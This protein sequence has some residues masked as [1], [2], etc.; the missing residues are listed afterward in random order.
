MRE[1]DE[2]IGGDKERK[3][4]GKKGQLCCQ[5]SEIE[6]RKKVLIVDD[7]EINVEI[8]K[9]LLEEEYALAIASNGQQCLEIIGQFK[10]DL[11]LLDIVMP[12]M[13]GYE[14]CRRIKSDPQ[15]EATH[16][17]LVS[18]KTSIESRLK[19]YDAGTDDY[20]M[21]PFDSDE[22]LAKIQVQIR[23]REAITNLASLHAQLSEELRLAGIV[24]RDFLP[25]KL[26][27]CERLRWATF[28]LPAGSVSGDIY[29]VKHI[30]E[31]HVSFYVA[32]AV[33]HGMPAALLSIFIKQAIAMY[34]DTQNSSCVL[35]PAEL[36]KNVNLRISAQKLSGFLFITC[37]YC[38]ININT[39]QLTYCRAGHPYPIL[40]RQK[41][42]PQHLEI[43]GS[44]LGIVEE[45]EYSQ[46]TIQLQSGDKLLLYSD[47]A[48][49]FIS[50]SND[51]APFDFKKEFLD[52]IDHSIVEIVDT[53]RVH[54]ENKEMDPSE[55]DDIT[56]VGLEVL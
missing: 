25:E 31:Q 5:T 9:E 36:M 41:E 13:D 24:Q 48:I 19:G 52:I 32:D 12:G 37:C 17:I 3:G 2:N 46:R 26:P 22:L 47:G 8:L 6:Y 11:V 45:A 1:P 49:P 10:P 27:N 15:S 18:S 39:L 50:N 30:D 55:I 44:L 53:L 7:D 23:L 20:I 29:D 34:E 14:T 35:T 43:E 28:I 4:I 42:Q 56:V 40:I 54:A 38:L 16:I 21:R 33:G 51:I